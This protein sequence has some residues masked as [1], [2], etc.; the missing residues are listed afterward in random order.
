MNLVIINGSARK[1]GRTGIACRH[2]QKKFGVDLIDLSLLQL[3]IFNGEKEQFELAEYKWLEE[4][5]SKADGIILATP[6]YHNGMS[7]ALKNALDFLGSQLFFQKPVA[8]LAAAGGG[9]GGIN[10][11]N[12]MRIVARGLYANV[13]PRQL[14]VDPD[15]FDY[16]REELLPEADGLASKMMEELKLFVKLHSMMKEGK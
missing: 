13:I 8:L 3:P 7:G 5:V 15:C 4:K 14:I 6:E 10:A 11:L 16:E 1:N 2:I 12:N 9:K